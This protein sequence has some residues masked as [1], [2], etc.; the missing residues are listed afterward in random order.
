MTWRKSDRKLPRRERGN[1]FAPLWV[2]V[3][4][5][6]K[7]LQKASSRPKIKKVADEL[8]KIFNENP[9]GESYDTIPAPGLDSLLEEQSHD[10]RK[11]ANFEVEVATI[12]DYDPETKM[13]VVRWKNT[14]EYPTSIA[15][16]DWSF[17]VALKV[18]P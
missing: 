8:L 3:P 6:F 1:K 14:R 4:K 2:E 13:F 18:K 12:E 5:T 9:I 7:E 10:S 16:L 17:V 11:F 15:H